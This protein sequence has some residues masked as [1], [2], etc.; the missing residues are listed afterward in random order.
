MTKFIFAIQ[1]TKNLACIL[2]VC[3]RAKNSSQVVTFKMLSRPLKR[4][5]TT[6]TLIGIN[7]IN[8]DVKTENNRGVLPENLGWGVRCTS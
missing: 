7:F 2:L 6:R 5:L 8:V 3:I 4:I 1:Q